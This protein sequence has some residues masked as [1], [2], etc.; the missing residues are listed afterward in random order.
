VLRLSAK[1]HLLRQAHYHLRD[2]GCRIWFKQKVFDV[3]LAL[4][5]DRSIF[6]PRSL[7]C[8]GLFFFSFFVMVLFLA[9][10]FAPPD[11]DVAFFCFPSP[12]FLHSLPPLPYSITLPRSKLRLLQVF[13]AGPVRAYLELL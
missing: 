13:R 2:L 8:M 12:L 3:S 6:A 9:P 1:F 4:S 7:R 10:N 11:G 5:Y